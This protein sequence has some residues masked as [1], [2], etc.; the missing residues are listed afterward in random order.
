MLQAMRKHLTH[1]SNDDAQRTI[2]ATLADL[3]NQL[4]VASKRC[5]EMYRD[6]EENE[7][8][9]DDFGHM[10]VSAAAFHESH[11]LDNSL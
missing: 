4:L 6:A 8:I 2:L 7:L 1:C 11:Q 10:A 9:V 3:R 5:R